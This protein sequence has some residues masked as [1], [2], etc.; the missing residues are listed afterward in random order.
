MQL[1]PQSVYVTECPT[2]QIPY[3]FTLLARS[4]CSVPLQKR[5]FV[6]VHTHFD[7]TTD[8]PQQEKLSML[9]ANTQIYPQLGR[10]GR[11]VISV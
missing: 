5:F 1:Q 9:A 3:I 10:M 6:I 7:V 4:L 11:I 8:L 2:M